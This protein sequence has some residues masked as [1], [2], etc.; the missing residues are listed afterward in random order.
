MGDLFLAGW[1]AVTR[2]QLLASGMS[3][4]ALEAAL[5]SGELVRARRD[6]YLPGSSPHD[7]VRAV[8]V[9]GR[10]TCL[11]LLQLLGV[12]V[13]GCD[14][15]HVHVPRGSGRLRSPHNRARPLAKGHARGARLHW[16]PL[17]R[18]EEGTSTCV[19]VMDALIHSVLCQPA[20]HAVATLDSALNKGMISAL[21][22]V[23]IFHALPR[24]YA[25]LQA[26]VDGRAQS[27]PETLVRLMLQGLGCRVELQVPFEGVGFVD[28]VV[29]GWL[30]VE[31]DSR[32][33]HSSWK[34]QRE[35]HRR[36][37]ILAS[38]GFCSFRVIAEDVLY[39]PEM[40]LASLRGLV[41]S[42]RPQH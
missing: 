18:P 13:F 2:A 20:R 25:V 16:A 28:L 7:V 26:L 32:A 24:K 34:A 31:C 37:A 36:D 29:D 8:R 19:G 1:E 40:V 35:D 11:S 15:V 21:D 3:R 39:R 9:G 17:T 38:Y 14:T 23:D 30:V 22:L 6:R 12:F 27:G 42:R 4:R 33:F 41:A 5:R 10:V